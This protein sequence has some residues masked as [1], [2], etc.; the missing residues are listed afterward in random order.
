M[1]VEKLVRKAAESQSHIYNASIR[2]RVRNSLQEEYK[3]K[4]ILEI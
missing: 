4:N 1:W 2:K 3:L